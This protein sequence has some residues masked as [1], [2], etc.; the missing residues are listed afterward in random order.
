VLL[1]RLFSLPMTFL[2]SVLVLLTGRQLIELASERQESLSVELSGL[3]VSAMALATVFFLSRVLREKEASE[4]A[5][6]SSEGHFRSLVESA[7][8]IVAVLDRSG[9]FLYVSPSIERV[10]GY[11][12]SELLGRPSLELVVPADRAVVAE[13]YAAALGAPGEARG[14]TCR[15]QHKQGG[16]VSVQSRGSVLLTPDGEKHGLLNMRDVSAE[17]RAEAEK[18]QLELELARAQKLRTLG[19]LAGGVAHDFNNV[20]TPILGNAE[21]ARA[22]L[23]AHSIAREHVENVIA[24]AERAKQLVERVLAF[25]RKSDVKRRAVDLPG[26]VK[27]ALALLRTSLPRNVQLATTLDEQA[28]AVLA[29]P[30]ELFQVVLN[31]GTNAAQAMAGAGGVLDVGVQRARPSDAL[32]ARHPTLREGQWLVLTVQD[33]GTGMDALTLA[34]AFEP[35][36]STR[37][38]AAGSGLGLSIVH[39]IVRGMGGVIDVQ[40]APGEGTRVALWLP[41]H[42]Q[43]EPVTTSEPSS[44]SVAPRQGRLLLVDDEPAV[45]SVCKELLSVLGYEVTAV[46]DVHEALRLVTEEPE[47]F[48]GVVTDQSMPKMT[49]V[50]LAHAIWRLRPQL[51]IVLTTGYLE[52][53]LLERLGDPNVVRVVG[54]PYTLQELSDALDQLTKH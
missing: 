5:L 31:L 54:K 53:D 49:G 43:V 19:T 2:A 17:Q 21:L 38:D 39:S 27:D 29:E 18:Q 30:I 22:S 15:L 13:V 50:E 10:L 33:G 35:F 3:F 8:D 32:C 7:I 4:Q 20:L 52:G 34:Q 26:A 37:R 44:T 24:A 41:A 1:R 47:R 25:A 23:P 46:A 42:G 6:R 9:R 16:M 12:P 36:F 28:G 40:S 48:D 45:L 11:R 51:P 14:V